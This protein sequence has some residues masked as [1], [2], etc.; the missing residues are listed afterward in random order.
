MRFGTLSLQVNKKSQ[1]C[2]VLQFKL[3]LLNAWGLPPNQVVV[4]TGNHSQHSVS[5]LFVSL[6]LGVTK[7]HLVAKRGRRCC[8]VDVCGCVDVCVWGECMPLPMPMAPCPC[9]HAPTQQKQKTSHTERKK[10]RARG[11]G[12]LLVLLPICSLSLCLCL[13]LL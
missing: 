8:Y 10:E 12:V 11:C 4:G 5:S 1:K 9:M 2:E 13:C 7:R 3:K 6:S